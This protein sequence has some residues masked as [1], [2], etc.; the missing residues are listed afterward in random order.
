LELQKLSSID[1]ILK[2]SADIPKDS[3]ARCRVSPLHVARFRT[4]TDSRFY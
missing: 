2:E 3:I 4:S 1:K